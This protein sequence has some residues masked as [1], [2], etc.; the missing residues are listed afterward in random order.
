MGLRYWGPMTDELKTYRLSEW[1]GIFHPKY[2][3]YLFG[4]LVIGFIG[5]VLTFLNLELLQSLVKTFAILGSADVL[6]CDQAGNIHFLTEVLVCSGIGAGWAVALLVLL[7]YAGLEL[8]QA[9]LGILRLFV[10]GRLEIISRNDIEREI[11][12][13]LIRKDDQFFQR[14]SATQIANR[15]SE[16]TSRIFERREDISAL[17]A[18][19]IQAIGALVF[20]WSQNWSYAAA[21]LV[22]SLGGV[23]IIHRMLGKM[24]EL[25]GEQLQSDDNVKGAFEDYLYTAPEAQM[26]NL[27]EKISD[28]LSKVQG[29][30]QFAFMG[31]VRLNGKLSA[32]YALTELVAFGAIM[33]A[34]VYVATAHGLTLEDG[35]VAAVVRAVPQLYGNIS[36][37]ARLYMK[38]QLADVSA[39]RLLEY[40]TQFDDPGGKEAFKTKSQGSLPVTVEKVR[41]SFSPGGPAQGGASGI[42]LSMAPA[43]LNVVVGPSGSG[44]S[45]LS[46]LIL[47]RLSPISGMVSYGDQV[48]SD[49]SMQERSEIFSYM[50]QT[51]AM[52]SGSIEENVEFGRLRHMETVLTEDSAKATLIDETTV[53]DFAREKSLDMLVGRLDL[54][55]TL[56]DFGKLRREL[57]GKIK[58]A[59]QLELVSFKDSSIVPHFNIFEH[60]TRSATEPK[61]FLRRAFSRPGFRLMDEISLMEGAETIIDL[62][63]NVVEKNKHLLARCPTFDAYSELAPFIIDEPVWDLRSALSEEGA[64]DLGD[65]E[66]RTELLLVGLTTTPQELDT[67][68]ALGFG[69]SLK[70]T[71]LMKLTNALETYFS[72]SF[73]V[74]DEEGLNPFLSW[75]D[76]LLFGVSVS[77]NAPTARAID[78][79]LLC[80]IKDSELDQTLLQRGMQY[81]VGRQGKRL[82]G[83]QRQLVCL[84][85]TLLQKCPILV[86]DEPTAALD[87]RRREHINALLRTTSHDYTVIVVTHDM[88]LA[89]LADQ[90]IMM[91]EGQLHAVGSFDQMHQ[92]NS[93]FRKLASLN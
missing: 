5:G 70:G 24:K 51:P 88:E 42:D 54:P 46:Q 30:R 44:K 83:G 13:N 80:S 43:S 73:E 81:T 68:I 72:G 28:E 50:P 60:L 65:P 18:V 86:L 48:V 63:H 57:R 17:W 23:F 92:E 64:M 22:F 33:C 74:L 25:D 9:S 29:K 26:G 10:E 79:A 16:D 20:L 19:S 62:G 82:S 38:F 1:L 69:Q 52:I 36:E 45:M 6:S 77:F 7:I 78:Q 11:L 66:V 8:L 37:V 3:I 84:C 87:P 47:G 35:L 75:R 61:K 85:R 89:R 4:L 31:L 12:T 58:T 32:T 93:E 53:G 56:K 21:V 41:Y 76:N 49:M 71:K 91:K 67:D 14:Q 90:V 55:E 59:T 34:I 39:K 40:E 27:T 2:R 15:L